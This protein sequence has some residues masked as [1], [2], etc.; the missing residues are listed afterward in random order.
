MF[1]TFA[2]K[3]NFTHYWVP[4]NVCDGG[5][6]IRWQKGNT[7]FIVIAVVIAIVFVQNKPYRATSSGSIPC[8]TTVF[9]QKAAALSFDLPGAVTETLQMNL[10]MESH[11]AWTITTYHWYCPEKY[12]AMLES[13]TLYKSCG[14]CDP[15]NFSTHDSQFWSLW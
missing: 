13:K 14:S 8:N 10:Q 12:V 5:N 9:F 15:S 4:W 2:L 7:R 6:I 3:K 11:A 1:V